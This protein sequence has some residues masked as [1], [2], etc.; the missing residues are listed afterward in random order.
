MAFT[1]FPQEIHILFTTLQH[2]RINNLKG[3]KD[4]NEQFGSINRYDAS[5][6]HGA[7]F[8]PFIVAPLAIGFLLGM[9]KGMLHREMGPGRRWE[10]GVPPVFTELHRRAHA[11]SDQPVVTEV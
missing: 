11:A 6:H 7:R 10:N 1:T 4:M 8:L 3:V 5:R 2:N 9:R